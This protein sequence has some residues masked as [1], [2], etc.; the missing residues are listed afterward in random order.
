M[1][2]H[3]S[4]VRLNINTERG[5]GTIYLKKE[6]IEKIVPPGIEKTTGIIPNVDL[7]AFYDDEKDELTIREP[8]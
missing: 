2:I 8:K 3:K 1:T 5:S 4:T 7:M 6:L